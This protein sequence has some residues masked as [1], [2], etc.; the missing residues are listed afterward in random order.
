MG[1]W[2]GVNRLPERGSRLG[3]HVHW[4]FE[5]E[6]F[7]S[8]GVEPREEPQAPAVSFVGATS[9]NRGSCNALTYRK[10]HP[11]THNNTQPHR[12]ET[13]VHEKL[14]SAG[15]VVGLL[16]INRCGLVIAYN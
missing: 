7:C 14:K 11:A 1:A 12:G 2:V 3:V 9:S 13:D 16:F 4:L 10:A 6:V 5:E 8:Q 15:E